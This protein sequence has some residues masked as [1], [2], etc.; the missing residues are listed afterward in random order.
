MTQYVQ[1]EL[2]Y[3]FLHMPL[4]VS[5]GYGSLMS[6][7]ISGQVGLLF[8]GIRG[9]FR[10]YWPLFGLSFYCIELFC[11]VIGNS[12]NNQKYETSFSKQDKIWR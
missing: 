4:A 12:L 11:S 1:E 10:L 5:S 8:L 2:P 9:S 6:L 7:F 3:P